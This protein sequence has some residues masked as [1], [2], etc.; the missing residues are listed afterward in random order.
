MD[1]LVDSVVEFLTVSKKKNTDSKML[2]LAMTVKEV[3]DV[4]ARL[5]QDERV[6]EALRIWNACIVTAS[7]NDR[8]NISRWC[9]ENDK[10]CVILIGTTV[11]GAGVSNKCCDF[12]IHY[13]G[14]YHVD[15]LLQGMGRAGRSDA[16][17]VLP[18]SL[19][20]FV[21]SV[22][23]NLCGAPHSV[24]RQDA[25]EQRK[26]RIGTNKSARRVA[27]VQGVEAYV[28]TRD[29]RLKTLAAM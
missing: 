29:C 5:N 11:V 12:V 14:A 21:Q 1:K 13:G 8:S 2:I 25:D 7:R 17:N 9:D 24:T 19:V 3:D 23:N 10:G 27:T 18:H 6:Q 22:V 16:R 26:A 4:F 28:F 15:G 20:L